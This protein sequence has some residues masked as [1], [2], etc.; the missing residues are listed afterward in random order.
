MEIILKK[1]PYSTNLG[2]RRSHSLR[3]RALG[4]DWIFITVIPITII[5]SVHTVR[6]TIAGV[7]SSA[8]SHFAPRFGVWNFLPSIPNSISMSVVDFALIRRSEERRVGKEC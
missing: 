5:M 6:V 8:I 2:L 1:T 4:S 3:N 7:A